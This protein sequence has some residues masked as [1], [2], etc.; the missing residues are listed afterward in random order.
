MNV[1]GLGVY[2]NNKVTV[3]VGKVSGIL[4]SIVGTVTSIGFGISILILLLLGFVMGKL[5][6][7]IALGILPLF[8]ISLYWAIKGNSIRKRLQR[9][10]QY[11]VHM[12]NKEWTS[13]HDLSQATGLS[14]K[15]IEKDLRKMI[16]VG[17]FPEGRIDNKNTKFILTKQYYDSYLK[18][19]EELE[20]KNKQQTPEIR[21]VMSEGR[22]MLYKLKEAN[23]GICGK[24]FSRKIYRLEQVTE[25]IFDY[26]ENHPDKLG[27]IR[28]FTQYFLP[29][30]LKLLEDYKR[31]GSQPIQGDNIS[32]AKREIEDTIDT[33][34]LAFENLL[35]DLFQEIAIDISTDISVLETMLIQEGLTKDSLNFNHQTKEDENE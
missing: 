23:Q 2:M 14:K 16:E 13:I 22:Q 18:Y 12:K 29:A 19:Q 25:K 28:K 35:D 27:E 21:K 10:N 5:F 30:T 11:K 24:Q 20:I 9:F 26:V 15:F 8:M 1:G 31:L 7:A 17:M 6:Y 33:I 32:N 4:L 3:G 34:N